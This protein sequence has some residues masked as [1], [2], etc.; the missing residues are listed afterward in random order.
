MTA[1][2]LDTLT[3]NKKYNSLHTTSE[4]FA[5]GFPREITVHSDH[6]N[7]DVV[8]IQVPY[9]HELYDEDGWDGEQM[10]YIPTVDLPRVKQL[11]VGHAF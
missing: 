1:I 8:F 4:I 7:R 10:V 5:G 3:F 6:T 9:G 11:I 2:N